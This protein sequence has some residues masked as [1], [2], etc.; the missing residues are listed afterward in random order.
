[1]EKFACNACFIV[2]GSLKE[3]CQVRSIGPGMH[4]NKTK[5]E[6]NFTITVKN[7]QLDSLTYLGG[8]QENETQRE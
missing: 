3:I 6:V 7:I 5:C 1:M 8:L 4:C 2:Y